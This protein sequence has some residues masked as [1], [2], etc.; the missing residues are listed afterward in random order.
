MWSSDEQIARDLRSRDAGVRRMTL[1]L[2]RTHREVL[3][4][5]VTRHA[6]FFFGVVSDL[7]QRLDEPFEAKRQAWSVLTTL[8][9]LHSKTHTVLLLYEFRVLNL[10][11]ETLEGVYGRGQGA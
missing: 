9:K 7:T 5:F 11:L 10:A 1:S 3:D 4:G 2:L 6:A 8:V